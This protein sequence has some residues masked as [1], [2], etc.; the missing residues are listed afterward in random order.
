MINRLPAYLVLI[1]C[2]ITVYTLFTIKDNVMTI[3]MELVEVNKQIQYENDTIH[4]LK[5]ELAYLASP[6]R[7]QRLNKGYLS[8]KETQVSQMIT[9]PII[10]QKYASRVGF[11][12]SKIKS[13]NVKWRYKKG[14]SKYVTLASGK[15]L[16]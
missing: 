4:L 14:P 7:L 1:L 5:A 11:A 15:K 10:E 12:D 8:L 3:R 9:D 6:E 16:R 2:M 13:S